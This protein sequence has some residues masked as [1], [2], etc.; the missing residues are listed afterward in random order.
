ML[1]RA[2]LNDKP[3]LEHTGQET[4][5]NDLQRGGPDGIP[6]VSYFPIGEA[7]VLQGGGSRR[8]AGE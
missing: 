5:I 3:E 6:E 2:Y 7:G 8:A 1:V 4:Y